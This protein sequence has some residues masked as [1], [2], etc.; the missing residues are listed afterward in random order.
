MTRSTNNE[1]IS[2]LET[3]VDAIKEDVQEMRK[4]N[5][6]DHA[7]VIE[8]LDKLTDLKNYILG[9]CAFAG[10]I[11]TIIATQVDWHSL[12]AHAFK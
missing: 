4:E 6:E 7:V 8:R 1:R 2:V 9:G 10:A 3:K 12:L 11:I 5:R